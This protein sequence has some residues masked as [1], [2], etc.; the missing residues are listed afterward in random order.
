MS[1]RSI[2]VLVFAL[3]TTYASM[4]SAQSV[5]VAPGGVYI[6]AGPVYVTP[7]PPVA[8]PPYGPPPAYP[9]PSVYG[10]FDNVYGAPPPGYRTHVPREGAYIVPPPYASAVVPRPPASIPYNGNARCDAY[11]RCDY[12]R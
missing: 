11:G 4:A 3:S 9:V 6:G 7:A 10:D 2:A 8:A 12:Y 5:Y 1:Y